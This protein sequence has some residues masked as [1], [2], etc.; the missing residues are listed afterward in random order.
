MGM[1]VLLS[2]CTGFVLVEMLQVGY[3]LG[4]KFKPFTCR[5]CMSGWA[6][7]PLSIMEGYTWQTPF[8]MCVAIMTSAVVNLLME[9]YL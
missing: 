7:L 4:L 3:L 1:I 8:V 6:A 9:K 2:V 5:D